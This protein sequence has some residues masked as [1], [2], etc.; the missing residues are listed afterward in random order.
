VRFLHGNEGTM[1]RSLRAC[2][3]I[4]R[5]NGKAVTDLS[6][7]DRSV[8][9]SSYGFRYRGVERRERFVG[10]EPVASLARLTVCGSSLSVMATG[11]TGALLYRGAVL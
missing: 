6:F 1:G 10:I 9:L 4:R 3:G 7:I 5:K 8:L 11:N 2:R